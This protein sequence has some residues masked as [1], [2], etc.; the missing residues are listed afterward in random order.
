MEDCLDRG[1]F[2]F[3]K[4]VPG[5]I[6]RVKALIH[7]GCSVNHRR[8]TGETPFLVA[9]CAYD[10]EF[11]NKLLDMGADPEPTMQMT[12]LD[13]KLTALLST[14]MQKRAAVKERDEALA[15]LAEE[16]GELAVIDGDIPQD[17]C[18]K[19]LRSML[20]NAIRMTERYHRLLKKKETEVYNLHNSM[21]KRK[22]K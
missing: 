1:I 4:K 19:K 15:R 14:V 21:G 13:A 7:N 17:T 8:A 10:L 18:P 3:F 6:C 9:T 20:V 22:R 11:M 12:R 5:A 2:D 16:E